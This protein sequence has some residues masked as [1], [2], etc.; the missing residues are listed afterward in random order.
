MLGLWIQP[1]LF[2][3]AAACAGPALLRLLDQW[4]REHRAALAIACLAPLAVAALLPQSSYHFAGH[5]GSYGAL[6]LGELLSVE[7]WG[8]YGTMPMAAGFAWLL[9]RL[10][11]GEGGPVLLLF[12]NRL[13]LAGVLWGL[14]LGAS[15][16][17]EARFQKTA[18]LV[19][20]LLAL[21]I[22]S[23]HGWSAT[24]FFVV[25]ALAAGSLGLALGLRG[26]RRAA[27]ALGGIAIGCRMET[28]PLVLAALLATG[29]F[30]WRLVGP[31]E[32]RWSWPQLVGG[33]LAL[34][35]F[36][37]E[38]FLLAGKRALV[39]VDSFV[40][41][42]SV[43]V[44]NLRCW[45]L[46]G[47][48]LE[49]IPLV[50]ALGI[51]SLRRPPL[52]SDWM[53]WGLAAGLA[54]ALLQVLPLVDLGA[55][56]L[57]PAALVLVPVLAASLSTCWSLD[58]SSDGASLPGKPWVVRGAA[59]LLLVS[60]GVIG[61]GG[62]S[63]LVHRYVAGYDAFLPAWRDQAGAAEPLSSVD[64][65]SSPCVVAGPAG[66]RRWPGAFDSGDVRVPHW[67]RG[68]QEQGRCVLWVVATDA[69][70]SGDTSAERLD[71]ARLLLRLEAYAWLDP[72]PQGDRPWLVFRS[73]GRGNA[74]D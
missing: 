48:F 72:P 12:L 22:P 40:P 20:P 44:E 49:P 57:L 69:E 67:I 33:G 32:R 2:V 27:I 4:R 60:V 45:A 26:D 47:P 61:L 1:L 71:R 41:E 53:G 52:R 30:R 21:L 68:R 7:E 46:G 16:L 9:G 65:E 5:E 55:R 56:H 3:V 59:V 64:L 62:L 73:A 66:A 18:A 34:A 29:P 63:E 42:W 14:S 6:S 51:V 28:I 37:V 24:G 17:A 50:L 70:F 54:A 15:A 31:S 25:P 11:L 36:L 8:S 23:L 38:A 43:V 10:G 35:V 39:P 13:A 58:P 19:A 74:V